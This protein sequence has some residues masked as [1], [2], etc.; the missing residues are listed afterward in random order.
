MA[1]RMRLQPSVTRF[2]GRKLDSVIIGVLV[3]A[4]SWFAWDRFVAGGGATA[5]VRE[6]GAGAAGLNRAPRTTRATARLRGP[7]R[8]VSVS[9]GVRAPVAGPEGD[10]SVPV[11]RLDPVFLID[12]S[13]LAGVVVDPRPDSLVVRDLDPEESGFG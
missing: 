1:I 12:P 13:V 7:R 3:V 6:D 11:R 9:A 10:L 4:L 2:T 8:P 5:E